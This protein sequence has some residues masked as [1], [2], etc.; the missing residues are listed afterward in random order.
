[1]PERRRIRLLEPCRDLGQPRVAGDERRTAGSGGLG[2]HHPERLGEDRRHDARVREREQVPEVPVL[3]RAG[4]ERLDPALG[5]TLLERRPL[6]AEAD[7]DEAGVRSRRARRRGRAPPSARSASRS[8]RRP[9]GRRRGSAPGGRRCPRRAGAPRALPGFG[10]SRRASS[11]SA[12][13][14][15][16]AGLGHPLVDIDAGRHLD[17]VLRVAAHL[18]EDGADVLGPDERCA[19]SCQ[20]RST[21]GRELRDCRASSTRA[22]SRGP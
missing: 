17:H 2:R 11:I 22:R 18:G 21:P 12:A 8:R 7:D 9:G 4:E 16:V 10:A 15:G 20:R 1:M 6:R 19:R 14:G 13:S 5:G 3:E